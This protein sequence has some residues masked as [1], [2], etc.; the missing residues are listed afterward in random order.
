MDPP[1]GIM[2]AEYHFFEKTTFDSTLPGG[3]LMKQDLT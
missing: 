3:D 1:K 2:R